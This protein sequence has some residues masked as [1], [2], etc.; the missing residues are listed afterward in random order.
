MGVHP[1][2]TRGV[3]GYLRKPFGKLRRGFDKLSPNGLVWSLLSLSRVCSW[4]VGVVEQLD[5]GRA[6]FIV[7][8]DEQMA[9]RGAGVVS[10]I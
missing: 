8:P 2:R 6:S 5:D 1:V 4:L 10:P 3:G 7:A 9:T